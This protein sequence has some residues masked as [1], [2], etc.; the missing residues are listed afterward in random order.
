[1]LRS[2]PG[3][4]ISRAISHPSASCQHPP[5]A[6]WTSS[7][8]ALAPS[9]FVFSVGLIPFLV[10]GEERGCD[11]LPLGSGSWPPQQSP[12]VRHRSP[13]SLAPAWPWLG[14]VSGRGPG[15]GW[16]HGDGMVGWS[17]TAAVERTQEE[18]WSP[19]VNLSG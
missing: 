16:R 1:M 10:P 13:P 2:A 17:R 3:A 14:R 18:G 6:P 11:S 5:P 12:A 4:D 7:V 9:G 19:N 15:P 8:R